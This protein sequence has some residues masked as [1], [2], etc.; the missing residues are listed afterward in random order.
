M[1]IVRYKN[2]SFNCIRLQT[3]VLY[4]VKWLLAKLFRFEV[5]DLKQILGNLRNR[6]EQQHFFFI[7]SVSFFAYKRDEKI[8]DCNGAIC[9]ENYH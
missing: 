6:I 9:L 3:T 1:L 4:S 7:L 8:E 5:S 2:Q